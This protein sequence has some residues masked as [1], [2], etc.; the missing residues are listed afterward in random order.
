MLT[1]GL[2]HKFPELI[3]IS[4]ARLEVVTAGMIPKGASLFPA[5]PLSLHFLATMT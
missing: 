3:A 2:I 4:R 1:G 5:P